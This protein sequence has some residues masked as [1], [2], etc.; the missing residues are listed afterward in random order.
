V[1]RPPISTSADP[2]TVVI[3]EDD[4][5]SA[6][7]LRA[8]LEHSG[9]DV[10]V[11]GDGEAAIR[12][13]EAR[14]APDLLLLDWMLPGTTGLE[15]CHWARERWDVLQLPILMVT[16]R[17]DTESLSAAFDAGAT[18]YLTKPFLGTELRARIGAHLRTKRLAEERQRIE[19]HLREQE[20]LSALGLLAGG[21][22]HDLGNP[23][24]SIAGY[25]EL[26]LRGDRTGPEAEDL[27]A[28][29][30]EVDRCRRLIRNLLSF[31][32]RQP[33]EQETVDLQAVIEGV[34][35]LCRPDL[36]G[37]EVHSAIGNGGGSL[38]TVRGNAGQLQQVFV[39]IVLNAGHALRRTGG[40]RLELRVV[41]GSG[42]MVGVAVFNDADPIPP[43][44]L[45]HIFEPF[46]T[47]KGDEEGT[48]L[49]LAISRR[50]VREHGGEIEAESDERGTCFRITLPRDPAGRLPR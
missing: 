47:T 29:L 34:L 42:E 28:I 24:G 20:R 1:S 41:E 32:R 38:P 18:D 15:V 4:P 3:A 17:T 21:V 2:A 37:V 44:V 22:A 40:G 23:L 36:R 10:F 11:A 9:H 50:I 6:A 43:E 31:A 49:G 13:L 27:R 30:G 48:G 25:A 39:N 7:V 19:E 14:G 45:P 26:L 35:D 8:V 12:H 16:A 5:A 33:V 46:Y